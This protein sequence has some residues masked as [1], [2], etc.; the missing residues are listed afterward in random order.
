MTQPV[1]KCELNLLMTIIDMFLVSRPVTDP[2]CPFKV[3]GMTGGYDINIGL[4]GE[5]KCIDACMKLKAIIPS[6]NGIKMYSNTNSP[7]CWCIRN[8]Y[9]INNRG[10]YKT[11]FIN[12]KVSPPFSRSKVLPPTGKS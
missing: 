10:H 1:E 3:G 6:I 4:L 2:R 12:T 9:K 5:E 7:G 8:L 11:C